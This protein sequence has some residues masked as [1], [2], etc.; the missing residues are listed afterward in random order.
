MLRNYV[1]CPLFVASGSGFK[2]NEPYM[3]GLFNAAVKLQG[4]YTAGIITSFY[5]AIFISIFYL[6]FMHQLMNWLSEDYMEI[7]SRNVSITFDILIGMVIFQFT[8]GG[9][10]R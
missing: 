1:I 9:M 8:K 5:V 7:D 3:Y 10:T 4:G 6:C 2:P